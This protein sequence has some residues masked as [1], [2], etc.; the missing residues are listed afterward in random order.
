LPEGPT[1]VML[2]EQA[3]RFEGRRILAASGNAKLDMARLS[4]R[5]VRKVH[6]WGKHFLIELPKVA[7]R[8]H[9]LM[10]GSF[11]IDAR[12]ERDPR[13]QLRFRNGEISFYSCAVRLVEVPLALIY[14]WSADVMSD[15]WNAAAARRKLRAHPETFICDAL[16]DQNIFAGVGNIIKNEVLYRTRVHP[17]SVV[18]ALPAA[19]LRSIVS[20]ARRYSFD[21]LAWRRDNVL[22]KHWLVHNRTVCPSCGGKLTRAWLGKT[23]RRS[24]FCDRCQLRH[25]PARSPAGAQR[26]RKSA[27]RTKAS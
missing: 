5:T 23:D 10:F 15:E 17:L 2:R 13:L 1:I 24:F 16:L 19:E 8:V 12:K 20:E 27:P 7:V 14:D 3:A 25:G 6:S 26:A 18:G 4:G 11:T 9:F 22:R 21:F